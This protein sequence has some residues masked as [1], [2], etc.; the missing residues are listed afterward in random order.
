MMKCEQHGARIALAEAMGWETKNGWYC[1]PGDK[2]RGFNPFTEANDDYAVLVF[3]RDYS[4]D[5]YHIC[6]IMR[7]IRLSG[8]SEELWYR[9]GDYARAACKVLGIH[10]EV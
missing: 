7:E 5:D 4:D 8:A 6:Q 2:W 1:P 10:Y 9:I 3:L